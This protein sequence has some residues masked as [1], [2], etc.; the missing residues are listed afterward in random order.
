MDNKS[1]VAGLFLLGILVAAGIGAHGY[2]TQPKAGS[3]ISA[4]ELTGGQKIG[5]LSVT[6]DGKALA[7][8]DMVSMQASFSEID[9]T[10]S[11]ALDKVNRKLSEI[12]NIAKANGVPD[13]DVQTSGLS[14]FPEYEYGL[15]G[16]TVRLKG[17][18][19]TESVTIT[20]RGVDAK[21]EKASRVID[22]ISAI[23]N[24]QLGGISFDIEDKTK[25]FTQAREAAF[26]KARQKAEELS[27]LG[28]VKLTKP[29]TITDTAIE[30]SPPIANYAMAERSMIAMDGGKAATPVQTGELSVTVNLSVGWGIE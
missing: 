6:G 8:P 1:S 7:R 18:R 12:I 15:G 27:K 10:S 20:V 17:Q 23:D 2:L 4:S 3:P 24:V 21:A 26:Q 5:I 9:A 25:L 19:A 11:A 14:I 30:Y 16:G 13:K 28:G 22:Q 29:V